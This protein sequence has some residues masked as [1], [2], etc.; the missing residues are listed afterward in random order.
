MEGFSQN[1]KA[2]KWY[3]ILRVWLIT[4]I[5]LKFP[6][7]WNLWV[8]MAQYVSSNT[9]RVIQMTSTIR[10]ADYWQVSGWAMREPESLRLGSH[11]SGHSSEHGARCASVHQFMFDSGPNFWICTW[12][13]T[14]RTSSL[15]QF[16]LKEGWFWVGIVKLL[17]LKTAPSAW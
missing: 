5:T 8:T 10:K 6:E 12:T 13:R 11:I 16:P 17:L 2:A 15:G 1:C 3:I 7:R 4:L 14:A 9:N